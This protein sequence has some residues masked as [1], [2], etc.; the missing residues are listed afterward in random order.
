MGNDGTVEQIATDGKVTKMTKA[1]EAE[2]IRKAIVAAESAGEEARERK[3]AAE[4]TIRMK[5]KEV[6]LLKS[7]L[8]DLLSK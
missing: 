3:I 8:I 1:Q 4:G 6:E 5:R 7:R 2:A